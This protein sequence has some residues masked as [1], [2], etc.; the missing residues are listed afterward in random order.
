MITLCLA[1]H[2]VVTRNQVLRKDWSELLRTLWREQH[3]QAHEQSNLAFNAVDNELSTQ[4]RFLGHAALSKPQTFIFPLMPSICMLIFTLSDA[5][6][7]RICLNTWDRED[8]DNGL[9]I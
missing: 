6:R 2:A 9:I 8:A 4:I 3:P 5:L 7:N 1:H